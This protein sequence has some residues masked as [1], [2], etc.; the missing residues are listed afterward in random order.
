[1]TVPAE[2]IRVRRL[3]KPSSRDPDN[4]INW[5]CRAFGFSNS[6]KDPTPTIFREVLRAS[7]KKRQ[8][9]SAIVSE[10]LDITRGGVVYHLNHMIESGVIVRDGRAY[11]LR[12]T[13]LERTVDEVEED[14]LRMFRRIKEVAREIDENA[15]VAVDDEDAMTD[16][17]RNPRT[18]KR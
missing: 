12:C 16:G 1:M 4:G 17:K 2:E 15:G 10:K 11:R 8:V 9:G 14:M 5:I 3:E 7:L 6:D 13:T 18:K